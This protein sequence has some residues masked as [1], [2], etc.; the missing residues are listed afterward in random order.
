MNRSSVVEALN[1]IELL[2]SEINRHVPVD[3]ASLTE[4]RSDLAGLLNVTVCATY[5]N[6]VKLVIFD[7]ASRQHEHFRI[8]AENNY[9]RINSRIDIRDLYRYSKIFHPEINKSFK[10]KM[11]KA[12]KY[13]KIRT[14][15]DI[16]KSYSQLLEWRHSFAH[17]G[18]RV[19]TVEEVMLH[20]RIAKRV[21]LLF[22]DA[23]SSFPNSD[24]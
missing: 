8:Y 19:T 13:F 22:A 18:S 10:L 6:C 9:D 4:F 3:T 24:L 16:E 21:I 20:H 14:K 23:F 2:S 17:T 15:R 12:S 1:R 11:D 7:Y 5:E